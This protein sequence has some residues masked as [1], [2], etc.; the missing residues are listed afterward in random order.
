[1]GR[2]VHAGG[3]EVTVSS[4]VVWKDQAMVPEGCSLINPEGE[5]GVPRVVISTMCVY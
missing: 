3:A 4:S 2:S 1:M 5:E